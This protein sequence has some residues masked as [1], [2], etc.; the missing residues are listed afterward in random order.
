ML[1][2]IAS[3]TAQ[4]VVFSVF[5]TAF[6]LAFGVLA[7]TPAV[8]QAWTTHAPVA[9]PF[10][11]SQS[12][13]RVSVMLGAFC[14]LSFVASSSRDEGYREAFLDPIIAFTRRALAVRAA[15]RAEIG[16]G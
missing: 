11:F 1:L 6:F 15:Y 3:Q 2:P 12:L 8:E 9:G 5:M 14:G 7:I 16:R 13:L 4:V 10:G